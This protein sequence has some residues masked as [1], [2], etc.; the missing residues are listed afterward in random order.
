MQ[1]DGSGFA[2]V[3]QSDLEVTYVNSLYNYEAARVSTASD[4]PAVGYDFVRIGSRQQCGT[5]GRGLP[6]Q[7]R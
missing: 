4:A 3:I 6:D 1:W 5:A 2:G 7:R